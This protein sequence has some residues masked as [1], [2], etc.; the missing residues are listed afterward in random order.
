LSLD[1]E[2]FK[3]VLLNLILNAIQAMPDGGGLTIETSAADKSIIISDTGEG[4]P[5]EN[6]DK[7]FD[8][9]YTTKSK[10]TGLGLPTAYKIVKEHGG[11]IEI[12][13]EINKGTTVIIRFSKLEADMAD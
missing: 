6:L 13:S 3:T 10:G 4:I 12:N 7:I 9:F 8:L 5:A 1:A 11:D 2:R